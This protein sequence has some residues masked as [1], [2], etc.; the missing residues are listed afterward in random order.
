MKI[1]K[2]TFEYKKYKE[3]T[4]SVV[5]RKIIEFNNFYK[6]S[7]GRIAIRNQRSRWGSC[8]KR[9]NLNFNYRLALIPE[10]LADYV[11]V[12]EL[13]HLGEFNHSKNFWNLMAQTLPNHTEL[14][15]HLRQIKF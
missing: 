3:H 9:G 2:S 13:C 6:F 14:R 11:I 7:I 12:H 1:R 10:A 5:T 4:R 15:R 8:S